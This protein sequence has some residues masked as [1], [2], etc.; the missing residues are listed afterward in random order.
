MKR[1]MSLILTLMMVCS[2]MVTSVFATPESFRD[3]ASNAYY[4][5]A[6]LWAV[7]QGITE[8]LGENRF[9]PNNPCTRGQIMTMLW[10]AAGSPAHK[11]TESAF[12]DVSEGDYFYDAVMW[13]VENGVTAGIGGDK[14]GPSAPCT[15]AQV[16]TFLWKVGGSPAPN[17][18]ANQFTDVTS[19]VHYADAVSWALENKVTAGV[20]DR[21]FGADETCTRA[22]VVTFL[23]RA[24][25]ITLSENSN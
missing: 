23:W 11:A 5:E 6:V 1:M 12:T 21:R 24:D 9:G 7:Q 14:F 18:T 22:Q 15:R 25:Q 3:V 16:M 19:H 8:G 20:G 10:R 13:A 4:H 2:C 17:G